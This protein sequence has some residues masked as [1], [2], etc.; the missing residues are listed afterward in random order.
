MRVKVDC[1]TDDDRMIVE[2]PT[3]FYELIDP[4]YTNISSPDADEI[5][6]GDV[7]EVDDFNL[8]LV[9]EVG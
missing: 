8:R 1:F 5:V 7:L 6:P 4:F 9:D 3:G 2:G